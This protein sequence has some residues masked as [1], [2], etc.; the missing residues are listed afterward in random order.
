MGQKNENADRLTSMQKKILSR[1]IDKYEQSKTYAGENK[2]NQSFS[3]TPAE[4]YPEYESNYEPVDNIHRFED[5][6]R[7]LS[8]AGLIQIESKRESIHKLVLI[9]DYES[10]SEI[11]KKLKRTPRN[12]IVR[13]Q[14]Q[15]FSSRIGLTGAAD[16]FC[17]EQLKR[18]EAGKK[19]QYPLSDADAIL[20][21]LSR[22]TDNKEDILERELS[23][24]VLGDSKT[25]EKSYRARVCKI[26]DKFNVTQ[27]TWIPE[28]L[29]GR[30][31]EMAILEEYSVYANPSY[32]YMKG[33]G[34]ITFCDGTRY[35]LH[36]DL[37]FA[38]SSKSISKVSRFEIED[39]DFMTVENLT[40]FN[41]ISRDD[42][43]FLYLSGYHNTAKQHLLL[44]I[45]ED[46]QKP[47]KAMNFYHFGDIDPDGFLILKHLKRETNIDFL[48]Y[49]MGTEELAKY[50]KYS[51]PL[52]K[53]DVTKAENMLRTGI[54]PA[55]MKYMLKYGRKLEQEIIS[56]ME[57]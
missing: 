22:I 25:F 38:F 18:I 8:E 51:K 12:D 34:S 43:F 3:V 4:I 40:S 29:S 42:T 15:F 28:D 31:R 46:N 55:E 32:I 44:K 26:L 41:R 20:R 48:P 56:W 33:N 7:Q 24:E 45:A 1:L 6:M 14:K 23:I 5:Q 53:N 49:R 35:L 30:E 21:L 52:E 27:Q 10:I 47:G 39:H 11:Y 19:I 13:K 36:P 9:S 2:V 57:R 37:P 54:Y 16:S 17:R 50:E